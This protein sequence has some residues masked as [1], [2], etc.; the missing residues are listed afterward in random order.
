MAL[1]GSWWRL[2]WRREQEG[3]WFLPPLEPELPLPRVGREDVG[4]A[5][6]PAAPYHGSVPQRPWDRYSPIPA[7]LFPEPVPDGALSLEGCSPTAQ[8]GGWGGLCW[9]AVVGSER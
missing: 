3:L 2:R 9:E 8:N 5:P 7:P 4:W 1:S 6:A